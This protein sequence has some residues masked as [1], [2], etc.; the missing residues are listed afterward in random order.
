MANFSNVMRRLNWQPC[1]RRLRQIVTE[2]GVNHVVHS[3]RRY[4]NSRCKAGS[5]P[6]VARHVGVLPSILEPALGTR[7]QAI[8]EANRTLH[9]DSRIGGAT[10]KASR[11]ESATHHW[12]S[13]REATFVGEEGGAVAD[14]LILYRIVTGCP[15][16]IFSSTVQVNV[17]LLAVPFN[18]SQALIRTD[19]IEPPVSIDSRVGQAA[20]SVPADAASRQAVKPEIEM[21]IGK[22]P[23]DVRSE[24]R[25]VGK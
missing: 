11:K 4:A 14:K 15:S 17:E 5:R 3:T 12:R 2:R 19:Q 18:R 6:C 8:P 21:F 16:S 13:F 20:S 24:E 22:R 7:V 1:R 23:S 9:Q 10:R 25:R